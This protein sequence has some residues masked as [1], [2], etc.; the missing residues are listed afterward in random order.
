MHEVLYGKGNDIMNRN[1]APAQLLVFFMQRIYDQGLT[2]MSGGN[3]S[4]RD[5]EG[6]IW[7]T[8]SGI[9]KGSLTPEDIVCVSPDGIC[10]GKHAPSC[11]L[12]FHS[13]VYRLRPDVR[14][15]LHAHPPVPV[16]FSIVRRLP[17]QDL[18]CATAQGEMS[19]AGY[20]VPGSAALGEKVCRVFAKGQNIAMME[21]HG[22]CVV[23]P[24]MFTAFRRFVL[25]NYSAELELAARRL[26][27]PQ[28]AP[29][30]RRLR[31]VEGQPG[32][33]G[34]EAAAQEI[35]KLTRRCCRTG[36]FTAAQG[37]CSVR[38]PQG[39]F[40]LTPSDLD[41]AL[42]EPEDLLWVPD[43][44]ETVQTEAQLHAALYR[45]RPEVNAV[46]TAQPPYLTAFAVCHRYLDARTIPESYIQLRD[47]LYEA[48]DRYYDAPE[49]V[50]ARFAPAKP[51]LL[52]ENV[53]AVTTGDTLLKAFDRMEVMEATARSVIDTAPL[54]EIIHITDEEIEALVE[55]FGLP[56]A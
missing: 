21:N 12:P 48:F 52:A 28:P 20:D 36:L 11:E 3:L 39:G 2:T 26:G 47:V 45:A 46:I 10:H 38:L 24:E 44:T 35:L 17:L 25:L 51:A 8:P 29:C 23:A 13:G 50:A 33:A 4:V 27:T 6:N 32:P 34:A 37:S 30:V 22:V 41:L 55:A 18:V 7:I 40:L 54:G 16:S 19:M 5:E 56:R 31:P 14:A 49:A 15:I 53:G 42:L 43:G 9:D 1:I